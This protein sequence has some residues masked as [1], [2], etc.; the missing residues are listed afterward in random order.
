MNDLE[1]IKCGICNEYL[2]NNVD[3]FA[4]VNFYYPICKTCYKDKESIKDYL[5]WVSKIDRL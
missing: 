1:F 4:V 3:L 2:E 5:I